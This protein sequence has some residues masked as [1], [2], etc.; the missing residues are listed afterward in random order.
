LGYWQLQQ[1]DYASSIEAF[2][3]CVGRRPDWSDAQLNLAIA[4]WRKG[5]QAPARKALEKAHASQPKSADILRALTSLTI[6]M[7]DLDKATA[8]Q[9]KLNQLGDRSAE[10]S[11]NLGVALQI[12][13]RLE[14][15]AKAY[16]EALQTNPN[17]AEANLNLGHV[18]KSL[19]RETEAGAC[20]DKALTVKPDL[21]Q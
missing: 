10:L 4:Y 17:F 11:Y 19:G 18:L 14:D 1:Q 6:E 13:K 5:E 8:Y 2:E 15:A 20:W 12:A 7:N 16:T 21:I 3:N 9:A